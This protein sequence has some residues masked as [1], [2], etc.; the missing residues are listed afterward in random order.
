MRYTIRTACRFYLLE[1]RVGPRGGNDCAEY[2]T[3]ACPRGRAR[4]ALAP[5]GG[6]GEP[7]RGG[8][9]GGR[10]GGPARP[11]PRHIRRRRDRGGAARGGRDPLYRRGFDRALVGRAALPG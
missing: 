9:R 2:R 8:E 6:D 1:E 3:S 11:W 10:G 5:R 4:A 7:G